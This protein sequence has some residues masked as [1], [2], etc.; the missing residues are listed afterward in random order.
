MLSSADRPIEDVIRLLAHRGV[1]AGFL[2]PTKTGLEKSILDAHDQL[3]AYFR[4]RRLHDYSAQPQGSDS[5]VVVDARLLG[6]DSASKSTAS[7]YRPPTKNGDPRIWFT[8]LP[9]YAAPGNLLAVFAIDGELFVVNTSN[10]ALL[11]TAN[12]PSSPFAKL[13]ARIAAA[14]A[15]PA[16]ELLSKLREISAMGFVRTLRKGPTGVG[17]TLEKLLGIAANS[18]KLPDFKGIEIKASRTALRGSQAN[19]ITL[20]SRVP[21]WTRSAMPNALALLQTHGYDRNGRRQLNCSVKSEPNSLGLRLRIVGEDLHVQRKKETG[22]QDVLV[23]Q[24]AGL[25]SALEEKHRQTFWV[26]AVCKK[27]SDGTEMFH[28]TTVVHTRA[29]MVANLPSLLEL[30]QV[31]L[32]FVMHIVDKGDGKKPRSRDHGYLFKLHPKNMDLL[33]PPNVAHS[34]S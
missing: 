29:P 23:W 15:G 22:S 7:L 33:F 3:R 10:E 26:K 5:K 13:L 14:S 21:D 28:Y 17:M 20:F 1:E 24:L 19:R 18:S 34:L 25:Q 2:V 4:K 30:G 16:E 8:G 9:K 12:V 32:D 31:E 6:V 11:A 27:D